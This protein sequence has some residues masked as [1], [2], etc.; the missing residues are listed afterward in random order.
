MKSKVYDLLGIGVG[1]FNL[2]LAALAE[3]IAELETVFLERKPGFDWHPGMLLP[4]AHLQVPFMADLVTMA[5]PTSQY[6]FLNYLKRVGRLYPFYIRENFY[7]LRAE[8]NKYCQW[9]AAKLPQV[10]FGANVLRVDYRDGLYTVQTEAES[11][12]TRRLALGTGTEPFLPAGA[13]GLGALS[14]CSGPTAD[15]GSA[16]VALH[17]GWYAAR[18]AE[19]QELASI[20]I[21]GSG[22]SAAEVYFDLLAEQPGHGYAL[23]WVTRSPRFFPLEYTKLT[24][25]MTSPEYVDYFHA[26]PGASRNRLGAEQKGLYKGI[27]GELINAIYDLLYQRS[28][29]GPVRTRLFTNTSVDLVRP[30]PD[31]FSLELTQTEQQKAFGLDSQGLVFATG[32][33]Y[34]EPDF[35][36]GIRHRINYDAQGRF[37]VDREY[38]ISREPGEIF[39]QNAEL[40]THGFSS[41]DLGMGAYRNSCILR[42]VL[43]WEY[44]EVE[45]RI[46]FQEFGIPQGAELAEGIGAAG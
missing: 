42:R 33:S 4:E 41:P 5:D 3:P 32:Y 43:G 24:L 39:V 22:Q 13:R 28:L 7:P 1:P 6:S 20:T 9:V 10:K 17:N 29:E 16:G 14:D 45:K 19:L 31:G 2:G 11:F 36:S 27:D 12:R 18:K 37:D 30:V 34:R 44:Y 38:S 23:N 25:E 35:L 21:V 26:L 46:G 8:Y 15:S 40:H